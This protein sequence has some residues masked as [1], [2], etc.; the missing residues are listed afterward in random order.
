MNIKHWRRA[1][2]VQLSIA[3][4][5]SGKTFMIGWLKDVGGR[6]KPGQGVVVEP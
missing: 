6:V 2:K 5:R 1:W 3:T 4:T